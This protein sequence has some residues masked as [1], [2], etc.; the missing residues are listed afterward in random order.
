MLINWAVTDG[1][2][3]FFMSAADIKKLYSGLK[4]VC[5]RERLALGSFEEWFQKYSAVVST[6]DVQTSQRDSIGKLRH[7]GMV[8]QIRCT[9]IEINF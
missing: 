2:L 6:R 8:Y 9:M 5:N 3:V 7:P 4:L 1:E